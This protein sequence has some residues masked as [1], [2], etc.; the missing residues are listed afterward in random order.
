MR[1]VESERAAGKASGVFIIRLDGEF[2]RAERDRLTD[3]FA[4]GQTA[5][6]IV[7]DFQRCQYIDSTILEC[8]IVLCQ[9]CRKREQQV[10]MVGLQSSVRRLF[11]ISELEEP[12]DI[13][14]KLEEVG[15]LDG[16][17]VRRLTIES[18]PMAD[19]QA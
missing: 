15:G 6:V 2:D 12:F 4:I 8:L 18:R 10:I 17:R 1:S 5:G 14:E 19:S 16:G 7:I 11:E 13:R 9:A 3:A